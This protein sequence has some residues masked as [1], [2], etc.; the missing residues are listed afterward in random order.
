MLF[1]ANGK[2]HSLG[3]FSRKA[4]CHKNVIDIKVITYSEKYW[5]F[6]WETKLHKCENRK[7][8][9]K[10][11]MWDILSTMLTLLHSIAQKCRVGW[12]TIN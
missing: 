11:Y 9:F 7:R 3:T 5:K 12:L 6:V 8:Y 4:T 1:L 2:I 10:C